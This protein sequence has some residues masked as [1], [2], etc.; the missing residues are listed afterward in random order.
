[1]GPLRLLHL[2]FTLLALTTLSSAQ[3]AS[4]LDPPT[5]ISNDQP[6]RDS[7]LLLPLNGRLA[8]QRIDG[9]LV[10]SKLWSRQTGAACPTNYTACQGSQFCCPDGN[11]CCSGGF[12]AVLGQYVREEAVDDDPCDSFPWTSGCSRWCL[13]WGRVRYSAYG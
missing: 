13:L 8:K 3:I 4:A 9:L 2:L 10:P 7:L 11:V 1:M 5:L 12:L 6:T